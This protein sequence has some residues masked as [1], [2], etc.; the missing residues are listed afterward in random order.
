[1]PE[2]KVAVINHHAAPLDG[3]TA[4]AAIYDLSGQQEQSWKQ[5]LTAAANACTDVFTLDWPASGA[6]LARLELRDAH[7]K[8]LSQ[9]FYWHARNENDLR[10]LNTLPRLKL[11]EKVRIQHGAVEVRITNSSKT[12]ALAV[13]VTLRDAKTGARTLPVYYDDNYFSLLPGE[14]RRVQIQSPGISRDSRVTLDGWN[15]EPTKP[16]DATR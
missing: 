16:D 9:N 4:T 7:G 10:Q 8:L 12:P 3:V 1:V 15:I 5:T 13:R 14:S 2:C 6:H 11:D